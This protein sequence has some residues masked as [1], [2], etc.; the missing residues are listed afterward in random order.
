MSGKRDKLHYPIHRENTGQG[1]NR[2]PK[3]MI[4]CIK[5]KR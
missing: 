5:L 3:D 4:N 1:V 2:D